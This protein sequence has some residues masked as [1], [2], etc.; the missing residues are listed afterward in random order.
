MRLLC[1]YFY[2]NTIDVCTHT[3][4][5]RC[6]LDHK[7]IHAKRVNT[8]T[9]Y[10][11]TYRLIIRPIW[12]LLF[13]NNFYSKSFI[14]FELVLYIIH[15]IYIRIKYNIE[16]KGIYVLLLFFSYKYVPIHVFFNIISIN[17]EIKK[18]RYLRIFRNV[19]RR[20][21]SAFK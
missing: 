8:L 14:L 3:Q 2:E 17:I 18:I 5:P 19:S 16:S 6:L 10:L 4:T 11:H 7:K 21:Y 12:D 13:L 9:P 20:K 15:N 1:T